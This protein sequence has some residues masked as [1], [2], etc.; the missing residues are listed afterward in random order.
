MLTSL[1]F[2]KWFPKLCIKL[3]R[4]LVSEEDQDD[5]DDDS[6]SSSIDRFNLSTSIFG[7][8]SLCIEFQ[9]EYFH[10]FVKSLGI[11]RPFFSHFLNSSTELFY[12]IVLF[13]STFLNM[14]IHSEMCNRIQYRYMFYDNDHVNPAAVQAMGLRN[15]RNDSVCLNLTDEEFADLL[16]VAMYLHDTQNLTTRFEGVVRS[17]IAD[18]ERREIINKFM[19]WVIDIY[20]TPDILANNH[21]QSPSETNRTKWSNCGRFRNVSFEDIVECAA[22][23]AISSHVLR[24]AARSKSHDL[25]EQLFLHYIRSSDPIKWK[26]L[27]RGSRNIAYFIKYVDAEDLDL[28]FTKFLEK[29]PENYYFRHHLLRVRKLLKEPIVSAQALIELTS[30]SD[31][32]SASVFFGALTERAKGLPRDQVELRMAMLLTASWMKISKEKVL[33]PLPPRNAQIITLLTVA[34]WA[35]SLLGPDKNKQMGK[36]LIAQVGTGEGKSLIIAMMAI[37]F[38]KTMNKRVHILENNPGLLDK[39][40][41]TMKPL[42]AEFGIK[43]H[44]DDPSRPTL[45]WAST[46]MRH[47]KDGRDGFAKVGVTYCLRRNMERYYQDSILAGVTG[48]PLANTVLI[49]DEVDDLIVD[50]APNQLFASKDSQGATFQSACDY[51]KANNGE[52]PEQANGNF[53]WEVAETAHHRAQSME[54]NRDYAVKEGKYVILRDGKPVELYDYALEYLNYAL[55]NKPPVFRSN[56]YC[57]SIPYLLSQYDC[58]TGFSGSVGSQSERNFLKEQFKTWCF[59]SP[60]FLDTCPNVSKTPPTLMS[61]AAVSNSKPC[62]HVYRTIDQ[63]MAKVI[64]LCT[65]LH[66]KVPVLVIAKSTKEATDLRD[67]LL[68]FM[69]QSAPSETE[70]ETNCIQLFL[71]YK[72]GTMTLDK[73]NWG[74]M[75]RRATTRHSEQ[76]GFYITVTDPFGGRGHDFDVHDD[77]VNRLGGLAV[78]MTSIPASEREWIQWKGRTARKDNAGQYAV[79]LCSEGEDFPMKGSPELL[80]DYAMVDES[81]RAIPNIY[82]ELLVGKLLAM[83]DE[84]QQAKLDVIGNDIVTG[85]R[86]NRLCDQFY[87]AYGPMNEQSWPRT[88]SEVTLRNLLCTPEIVPQEIDKAFSDFRLEELDARVNDFE[89]PV[90]SNRSY[91]NVD[92]EAQWTQCF[93]RYRDIPQPV[94]QTHSNT[95]FVSRIAANLESKIAAENPLRMSSRKP[96]QLTGISN[97]VGMGV[98]SSPRPQSQTLIEESM[99][100]KLIKLGGSYLLNSLVVESQPKYFASTPSDASM[101]KISRWQA[102]GNHEESISSI[103]YDIFDNDDTVPSTSSRTERKIVE[104]KAEPTNNPSLAESDDF[105]LPGIDAPEQNQITPV[106]PSFRKDLG[107]SVADLII[108]SVAKADVGSTKQ[109]A[110]ASSQSSQSSETG[111]VA[112]NHSSHVE[113]PRTGKVAAN[114]S[115]GITICTEK[116]A[117]N[118]L[119]AKDTLLDHDRLAEICIGETKKVTNSLNRDLKMKLFAIAEG[120]NGLEVG[121]FDMTGP[122]AGRGVANLEVSG[123]ITKTSSKYTVILSAKVA[124]EIDQFR[125]SLYGLKRFEAKW[126]DVIV[127]SE[128][129]LVKPPAKLRPNESFIFHNAKNAQQITSTGQVTISSRD[130]PRSAP[131]APVFPDIYLPYNGRTAVQLP[132]GLPD[133]MIT[134]TPDIRGFSNKR[135]EK[136]LLLN[137]EV[138][139][140]ELKM[141]LS[142]TDLSGSEWRVVLTWGEKPRDLDLYCVTNFEPSEIY[143]GSKNAGGRSNLSKGKIEL[144]VDK[145]EGFGPETI[146]F[147]PL[148][149]KKYRFYVHNFSDEK[150]LSESCANIVVHKGNGETISLDIPTDIVVDNKGQ[151]ARYWNVLELLGGEIRILNEVVPVDLRNC[152][153]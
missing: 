21:K 141:N 99:L 82:N 96:N 60:S 67:K 25:L 49:V 12:R 116:T 16:T 97:G 19:K 76:G 139:P 39:D 62:V 77:E 91:W 4:Q 79:V 17:M 78:I 71:E 51:L 46:E 89:V 58:I 147:T 87:R 120:N 22:E 35:K 50:D 88:Q 124:Q 66:S 23:A 151:H 128:E 113:A 6:N 54:L 1:K 2:L 72:V 101:H 86:L 65:K 85:R 148:V 53:V 56:Y 52:I 47:N 126:G 33:F 74:K 9:P 137:G 81:D 15:P 27:F 122:N 34:S 64:E 44:Q 133:A 26:D 119:R 24:S 105:M 32:V 55:H 111:K 38:V 152:T 129:V 37:F 30:S 143:Y 142:A 69:R 134:V 63:Q 153:F 61:D 93:D 145:R 68:A 108:T 20:V 75:V 3:N 103:S 10:D 132:R 45:S 100:G 57:Q 59:D 83:R 146:T 125:L 28:A 136:F 121:V 13:L 98:S 114:N 41:E 140:T 11:G 14:D 112:T 36:A 106:V 118:L 127:L 18:Q 150:A 115:S 42:Y 123:V 31:S 138:N 117:A 110:A 131:G 48:N 80:R 92:H 8:F 84:G 130:D 102:G 104:V 5:G 107:T 29:N 135:S 144:D 109:A 94:S 7:F 73:E 149:D 43:T 90:V 40:V 95:N 70:T